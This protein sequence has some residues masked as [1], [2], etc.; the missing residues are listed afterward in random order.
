VLIELVFV[1]VLEQ[2]Q[3]HLQLVLEQVLVFHLEQVL[4]YPVFLQVNL[5]H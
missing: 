3:V 2:V 1:Q 5:D 4:E